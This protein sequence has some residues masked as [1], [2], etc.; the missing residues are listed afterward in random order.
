VRSHV[1]G[2]ERETLV[3]REGTIGEGRGRPEI[4]YGLTAEAERL[5][6]R[7]EPEILRGLAEFLRRTDHED[8]L[9]DFLDEWLGGERR[10]EALARVSGLQGRERLAEVAAIL[11]EFGFMAV[12]EEEAGEPRLR[13]CH[14]PI[15]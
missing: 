12:V 2:L 15:R 10:S 1:K 4:V 14:C 8:L 6:P 13:L 11:T 5:F 9:D 7:R 3:R